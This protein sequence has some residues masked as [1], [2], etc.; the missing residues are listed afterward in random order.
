VD[1]GGS[2]FQITDPTKALE[3]LLGY[4]T[5]MTQDPTAPPQILKM[6]ATS[7]T[8]EYHHTFN[9]TSG[10]ATIT[11][12]QHSQANN[13]LIVAGM[14]NGVGP[15][16]GSNQVGGDD[17]DGYVAFLDSETGN[18]VD[19]LRIPSQAGKDDSIQDLCVTETDLFLV[20]TTQ[21]RIEGIHEKGV[22][23]IKMDLA[24]RNTMWKRQLHSGIDRV[25]GLHCAVSSENTD[26]NGNGNGNVYVAGITSYDLD[27]DQEEFMVPAATQD[28]FVTALD[29]A[30]GGTLWTQQLDT[31]KRHGD[32]RDDSVAAM[33]INP[34]TL[35][36]TVLLNSMNIQN[37]WN[38]IF[39]LDLRPED[40]ANELASYMMSIDDDE[41]LELDSLE[42]SFDLE[43]DVTDTDT[44]T[45]NDDNNNKEGVGVNQQIIAV[46][47]V[48]PLLLFFAVFGM[49][50]AM[51]RTDIEATGKQCKPE[52]EEIQTT[53]HEVL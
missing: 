19:S 41:L 35:N 47:I 20:G 8:V 45:T 46:A 6:H 4:W 52:D 3:A 16:F 23:L 37:E 9:L 7:G 39:L 29:R 13:L 27:H 11:S 2:Y 1:T 5:A 30:T 18:V 24:S 32:D 43:N 28:V 31:S 38:D 44:T 51:H 17:W 10:Q 50:W 49:K 40:G 22:F 15:V 33:E 21:G 12:I 53:G 25:Q 48:V 26:G 34:K 42:E 14:T 36:P